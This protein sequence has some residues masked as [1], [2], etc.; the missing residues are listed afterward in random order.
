MTMKKI[1]FGLL[2]V[3]LSRAGSSHATV[4]PPPE[5][6]AWETPSAFLLAGSVM[7][8]AVN[9][10]LMVTD[11]S[12][13]PAGYLAVAVG[14]L[15]IVGGLAINISYDSNKSDRRSGVL[16]VGGAVTSFVGFAAIRH[17]KRLSVKPGV[18][19]SRGSA[20]LGLVVNVS[21]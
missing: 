15:S 7:T 5:P 21:F 9:S 1:I 18:M 8:T 17:S 6:E 3:L 2:V 14:A 13:E 10:M 20:Q 16:M 4:P 11:Q 12:N 19:S